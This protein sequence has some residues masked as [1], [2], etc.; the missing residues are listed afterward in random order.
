MDIFKVNI[1]ESGSDRSRGEE[2][3]ESEMEE[4]LWCEQGLVFN[5]IACAYSED[6]GVVAFEC[7]GDGWLDCFGVHDGVCE[8]VRE[9]SGEGEGVF[10]IDDQALLVRVDLDAGGGGAR[11][12]GEAV[13]LEAHIT[14]K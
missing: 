4:P 12:F 1:S 2:M 9:S 3:F 11:Q 8:V 13:E 14:N 10:E 5:V 7:L 6:S